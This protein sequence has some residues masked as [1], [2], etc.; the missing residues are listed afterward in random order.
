MKKSIIVITAIMAISSGA[1]ANPFAKKPQP[2]EPAPVVEKVEQAPEV[3]AEPAKSQAVATVAA[4]AEEK[5]KAVEREKPAPKPAPVP[6]QKAKIAEPDGLPPPPF[7]TPQQ[8]M[9]ATGGAGEGGSMPPMPPEI[10]AQL[11]ESKRQ[12]DEALN[13]LK[14]LQIESE[15]KQ[16][17]IKNKYGL[18]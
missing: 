15:K 5:P 13:K 14:A 7:E 9:A 18:K 10:A 8:P 6:A 11:A 2:V 12:Q 4:K 16:E 1:S 17:E 3:Q